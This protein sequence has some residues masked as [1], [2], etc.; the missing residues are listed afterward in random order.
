[1]TKYFA[2][3]LIMTG[4]FL[5]S[6]SDDPEVVPNG[7][8]DPVVTITSPDDNTN[9]NSGD[10]LNLS[11]TATDDSAITKVNIASGTA[12]L[13]LDEDLNLDNIVDPKSVPINI[14]LT[15]DTLLA[16]GA[17]S[18]ELTATDDDNNAVTETLN[19]NIN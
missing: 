11:G 4:L 7:L 6:C 9:F 13:I 18:V 15:L 19:F 2:L 17:Y 5:I 16:Q 8:E 1:M 14:S 12:A 3:G 10:V